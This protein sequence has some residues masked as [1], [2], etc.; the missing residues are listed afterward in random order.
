MIKKLALGF[1]YLFHPLIM[2]TLG[3]IILFN[4]GTYIALLD[5][6]AKRAI[7]FVMIL[8]TILFPLIMVPVFYYRNLISNLTVSTR[9]ERLIPM[10]VVLLL[11]IITFIYFIRLPVSNLIHA[12]VLSLPVTLFLLLI[13]SM[14]IKLCSHM[15]GLGGLTGLIIALI[16]LFNTPLIGY[17]LLTFLVT[18][19]T[20]SARL[21]I[22]AQRSVEI[23]TGYLLGFGVVMGTILI[24]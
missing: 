12:Y 5:P 17:L 1:T 4:S 2:P 11:Y 22:G 19:I 24:Y 20:G 21:L 7:I 16:I 23:Y 3:L 13:F 10:L 15:V 6:A 14:K 8:G 9:E 18:G